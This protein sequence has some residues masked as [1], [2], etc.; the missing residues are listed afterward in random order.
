M[1]NWTDLVH[2]EVNIFQRFAE[3]P[4]LQWCIYL[5]RCLLYGKPASNWGYP[6]SNS[7]SNLSTCLEASKYYGAWEHQKT[8][9]PRSSLRC[10]SR[11][12]YRCCMQWNCFLS[13]V[14]LDMP[15]ELE[16]S[17]CWVGTSERPLALLHFHYHPSENAAFMISVKY[18]R[19]RSIS[20]PE[21]LLVLLKLRHRVFRI[22]L[23]SI[24]GT[25]QESDMVWRG[26]SSSPVMSEH[27]PR[28]KK[29]SL[30]SETEDSL[31]LPC[32]RWCWTVVSVEYIRFS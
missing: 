28:A 3:L 8:E 27:I 14:M 25:R 11:S 20:Q 12:W 2:V 32:Q 23:V 18:P 24:A 13:R 6:S 17:P 30:E 9:S 16:I 22:C 21:S 31:W 5:C 1:C 4:Y 15:P 26:H 10:T 29:K 19:N 7:V